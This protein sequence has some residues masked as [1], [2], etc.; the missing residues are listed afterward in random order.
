MEGV[1]D[2]H[3]LNSAHTSQSSS[4]PLL[5]LEDVLNQ[6]APFPYTLD[7]FIDFLSQMTSSGY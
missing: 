5:T 3:C 7:S 1:S 2:E 4:G 6:K